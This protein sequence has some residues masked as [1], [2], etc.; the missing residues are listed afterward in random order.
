MQISGPPLHYTSARLK[1]LSLMTLSTLLAVVTVFLLLFALYSPQG[2]NIT[3]RFVNLLTMK[4][5]LVSLPRL[6]GNHSLS[7]YT[8]RYNNIEDR[9]YIIDDRSTAGSVMDLHRS[10][11][12]PMFEQESTIS[13]STSVESLN[14]VQLQVKL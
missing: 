4:K 8:I 3:N 5:K 1:Q 2:R 13:K 9:G 7:G 11:E 6:F 10:F 14:S 12:N